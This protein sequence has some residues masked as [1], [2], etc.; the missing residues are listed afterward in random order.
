MD[1]NGERREIDKSTNL[2][3]RQGHTFHLRLQKGQRESRI[4]FEKSVNRM[5]HL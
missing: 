3:E 1:G 4:A 5:I 2:M